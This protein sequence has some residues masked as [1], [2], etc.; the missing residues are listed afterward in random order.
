MKKWP[1]WLAL[2]LCAGT[3]VLRFP[4]AQSESVQPSISN[5]A[6]LDAVVR[7]N[8]GLDLNLAGHAYANQEARLFWNTDLE[9]AKREAAR[10]HKPILMLR[11]LGNLSDEYS[12]AN[13]RFFRVV[14]YPQS[15]INARLKRDFVLCWTSERPVPVVTIDMGD[16][17]KL[18]RTLT[19]N[20]AH[21]L[22]DSSGRPLDVFPG[23]STPAAFESWL[24][25]AQ[26]LA[27]DFTA[28]PATERAAFLAK[29]HEDE[30]RQSLTQGLTPV[31][32]PSFGQIKPPD[33]ATINRQIAARLQQ[34][35]KSNP[36]ESTAP[37]LTV[38]QTRASAAASFAVSK[39][40]VE[41]PVLGSSGFG[42]PTTRPSFLLGT[43]NSFLDAPTRARIAAMN[44]LGASPVQNI[45]ATDTRKAQLDGL[46]RA[47]EST[48]V[49]DTGQNEGFAF[50]IHALFARGHEGDFDSLN[51]KIYDRLFLTPRSDEWLGLTSDSTFSALQNDGIERPDNTVRIAQSH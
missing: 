13:S 21:Y 8:P 33:E 11:L 20:S 14:F 27:S 15:E 29:W 37:I 16:G 2:P 38:A 5:Q 46:I 48:L 6:E 18:K 10:E 42:F 36:L 28:Q 17:R 45:A 19:G 32:S 7:Q 26:K 40:V 22:L 3:L 47:L 30:L 43:P 1:L 12:C 34:V 9:A 24:Q 39:M 4:R 49:A 35:F 25:N 31:V 44:P 41:S 51:R 23:L 50:N